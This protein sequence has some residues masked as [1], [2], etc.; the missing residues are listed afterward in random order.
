MLD[1]LGKRGGGDRGTFIVGDERPPKT[2]PLVYSRGYPLTLGR[3]IG[4][5]GEPYDSWVS[6]RALY[7]SRLILSE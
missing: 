7:D 4:S 3:S 1:A 6:Q 5:R 2:C